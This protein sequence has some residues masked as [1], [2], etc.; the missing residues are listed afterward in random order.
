LF[1]G[2]RWEG[3]NCIFFSEIFKKQEF[4]EK[5]EKLKNKKQEI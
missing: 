3:D 5:Q 1:I 2:Q 4:I